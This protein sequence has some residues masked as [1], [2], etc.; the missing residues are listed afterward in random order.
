M[1][2]NEI[3]GVIID[4]AM[5]VHRNLGPGLLEH[6]YLHVL[7][8]ELRKRA[9]EVKTEVPLPVIWDGARIDVGFRVDLLVDGQ[10]IVELKSLETLAPVH[11]KQ[12]LTYLRLA[13]K[14]VG[15]LINFGAE[16]LRD[17]IHRIAN[18]VAD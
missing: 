5:H 1:G 8:Q 18:G 2:L 4:A 13:D 14:R 6:V 11:K 7:S 10:V 12:L 9:H 3:T 16:F 17:G 15:L